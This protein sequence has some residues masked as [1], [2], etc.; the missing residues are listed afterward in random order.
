MHKNELRR[1]EECIFAFDLKVDSVCVNP[2]H[3]V[4]DVSLGVDL[5]ALTLHQHHQQALYPKNPELPTTEWNAHNPD[6][7]NNYNN[8]TTAPSNNGNYPHEINYLHMPSSWH[9]HQQ[10]RKSS[11]LDYKETNAITVDEA[12]N[13]KDNSNSTWTPEVPINKPKSPV[14]S[15]FSTN[16]PI[17]GNVS[18]EASE[19]TSKSPPPDHWC[20]I[21][22]YELDNP[23][24]ETFKAP[25]KGCP[26]VQIDGYVDQSDQSRFCLG[27]LSNVQRKEVSEETRLHI[28]KGVLLELE[29]EGDIWLT[30]QSR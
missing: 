7:W 27:A 4:R 21:T 19:P 29:G 9:N 17:N 25:S 24:G 16:L 20:S 13:N 6:Y 10:A 28:G 22:Y 12:T 15:N 23:V 1:S 3:Y 14:L 11:T 18:K 30:C 5:A 8:Y 2:Y 26:L